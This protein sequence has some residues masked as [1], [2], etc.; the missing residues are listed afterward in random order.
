LGLLKARIIKRIN[1]KELELLNLNTGSFEKYENLPEHKKIYFFHAN[2]SSCKLKEIIKDIRLKAIFN[3]EK[4][5]IIFS[6]F[7]NRFDLKNILDQDQINSSIYIDYKDEFLLSK[8]F[9]DDK[10]NPIIITGEDF[11]RPNENE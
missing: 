11:R 3:Q 2:C 10:E 1:E 7:A 8:K 5:T 4:V 9:T 6:V